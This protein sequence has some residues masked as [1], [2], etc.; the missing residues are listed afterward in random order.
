MGVEPIS[1][2]SRNPAP[3]DLDETDGLDVVADPPRRRAP[4]IATLPGERLRRA[5]RLVRVLASVLA[6]TTVVGNALTTYGYDDS[7]GFS[8][9][10]SGWGQFGQFLGGVTWSLSVAALVLA[11][12]YGLTALADRLDLDREL[13]ER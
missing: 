1:P 7:A 10:G 2:W 9:Y 6:V 5:A 13:A 4:R 11:A 3:T 12:S 8:P